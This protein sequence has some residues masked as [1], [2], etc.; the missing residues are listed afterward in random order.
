MSADSSALKTSLYSRT[1][2]VQQTR[3]VN[4]SPPPNQNSRTGQVQARLGRVRPLEEKSVTA[5]CGQTVITCIH[6]V[7]A[8]LYL[9]IKC[10]FVI[11]G[12]VRGFPLHFRTMDSTAVFLPGSHY[13]S[14]GHL[15]LDQ[16]N[17][18][19]QKPRSVFIISE[20]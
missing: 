6:P 2:C 20:T 15:Y 3:V 16:T 5:M 8:F 17:K 14:L 18:T 10:V 4:F 19:K 12:R 7:Q 9:L 13:N 1:S 11:S